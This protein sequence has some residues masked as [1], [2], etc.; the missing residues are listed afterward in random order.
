[1]KKRVIFLVL[2]ITL[3]GIVGWWFTWP[4]AVP[5]GDG[6]GQQQFKRKSE[7]TN[8]STSFVNQILQQ[9]QGPAGKSNPPSVKPSYREGLKLLNDMEIVYYGKVLDQFDNP[10]SGI[11]VKYTVQVNDG[12]R[13]GIKNYETRTDA[14]GS[15]VIQGHTG[16]SLSVRP[17][18]PGYSLIATNGGAIYSHLW[19]SEQRHVA[20]PD[21]P[22]IMRLWK[23]QGSQPLASV[24]ATIRVPFAERVRLNLFPLA[25]TNSGGDV[26]LRIQRG[27]DVLSR[28]KPGDWAVE[29]NAINGGLIEADLAAF[30][31][32]FEAPSNGYSPSWH[33]GKK[34]DDRYWS[35]GIK[36]ILFC[37]ARGGE[38]YGKFHFGFTMNEKPESPMTIMVRGVANTNGSRN[39]EASVP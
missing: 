34:A 33:S 18:K 17:E 8:A 30:Q 22:V 9:V 32:S 31:Y 15:F 27:T 20:D 13:E 7:A 11:P 37:K 36:G 12:V 5:H 29:V 25:V 6:G 2:L 4:K 21:R 10:L 14:L 19:P 1:M 26:E 39:W 16:K 3:V 28:E 38:L 24:D 23:R 35:T